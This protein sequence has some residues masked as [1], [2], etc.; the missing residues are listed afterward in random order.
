M[1]LLVGLH[2]YQQSILDLLQVC[3]E[4]LLINLLGLFWV[5]DAVSAMSFRLE[6]PSKWHVHN[7]FH[8]L[9]L[10]PTVS[11]DGS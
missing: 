11:Y 2:G 6:L 10:K 4:S 3:H 9:Q 7:V 5:T 1:L 8:T